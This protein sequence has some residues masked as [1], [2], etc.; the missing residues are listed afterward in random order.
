M[1]ARH[2]LSIPST[3]IYSILLVQFSCLTVL[4]HNLS[5]GPLWSSSWSGALYFTLHA[6]LHLFVTHAHTI[7]ACFAVI[8]MLCHLFQ[9]TLSSLLGKL[10]F[11]L[12]PHIHLTFLIS[13]CWSVSTFSFLTGQV[14]LPCN[15]LLRTQ[16]LYNV[17]PNQW[18]VLI[19]KQWYQLPELIP[20]NSNSGLHSCISISIHTEHVT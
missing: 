6:F 4:F 16:L 7:A 5:P 17:P 14:S 18:Y 12:T 2:P 19:G 9:I 11:S 1:F 3:T 10:S 8:S 13:T 15:I 20:T